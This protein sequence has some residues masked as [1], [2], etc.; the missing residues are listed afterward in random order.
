MDKPDVDFIEGLSPAISIDQKSAQPQP[1][2]DGRHHHR[3][4]RLPPAALRPRRRAALTPRRRGDHSARPPSRSST[5]SWPCP[6][7]PGS[8][9][10]RPSCAA[11]RASTT[12]CS[13]SCHA[14]GS[15]GPGSTARC[16]SW[17]TEVRLE[18]YVQ[19]DIEVIVDRLVLRAGIEQRLTESLE[20]ALSLADGDVGSS[21][22][23]RRGRRARDADVQPAPRLAEDG[24][25][26]DELAPR[27]F[28]FNSPYGACPTCDGLGTRYEVDPELV[29]PNPDIGVADGAIA[30]WAG[31][32]SKYFIRLLEAVVPRPRHPHRR[33]VAQPHAKQQKLLLHGAPNAAKVQVQY[34]NRYGRQ[35]SYSTTYEGVITFLQRRHGDAE[36]DWSRERIE[37]YMREVPCPTC[38]GAR[39]NE[40]SLNVRVD[41]RTIWELCSLSIGESA[42][43][44]AGLELGE[45][46]R[47]IAE[48]I[49]KEIDAR[50]QLP[51]RRRPRLPHPEPL[52]RHPGRRGGPAHPPRLPDRLGPRRGCC[53]CSTSRPSACTSG[54]TAAS[55]TRW[56][57]SGTSATP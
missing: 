43:V 2:L 31:A 19:H 16:G 13:P 33:P 5:G 23:P 51:A 55:S 22:S 48:P 49:R 35:R 29:V 30:P 26:F 12:P 50:L 3:G 8:R 25:S 47:L 53:T 4:L 14:R 44:I 56:C 18:R 17:P 28:S 41:G 39:L 10:W 38:G 45:R 6:T 46:D 42:K 36:S 32:S 34:R 15:P 37:G 11:A 7:A 57:G 24:R 54:T 21:S 9:C 27:N 52:G 40:V 20:N 1:T